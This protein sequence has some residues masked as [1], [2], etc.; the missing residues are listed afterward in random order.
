MSGE[1]LGTYSNSVNKGKWVSIP[2]EFKKKFTTQAKQTVIATIGPQKMNIAIYPLD[3][4]KQKIAKLTNG[5]NED[6]RLLI[7]LRNFATSELKMEA[8]GRIK[9][10][11]ELIKLVGIDKKVIIKGDGN[12]ISVWNPAS[13]ENYCNELLENFEFDV[14]DY[15]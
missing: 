14:M 3:N 4:W 11:E 6:K 10:S 2:A 7:Y 12:Y 1:F 15:Q 13:Y 9:I 8:N 5:S